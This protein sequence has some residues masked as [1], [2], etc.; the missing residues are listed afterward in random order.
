MPYK[1]KGQCVYKADTGKK[2]GCT[3]GP[4]K[5][6]LAA[7][8]A[9]VPDAKHESTMKTP[10]PS[11]DKVIKRIAKDVTDFQNYV[12]IDAPHDVTA[13]TFYNIVMQDIKD[14]VIKKMWAKMDNRQKRNLYGKVVDYLYEKAKKEDPEYYG[15]DEMYENSNLSEMARNIMQQR[16][17][18]VTPETDADWAALRRYEKG[19]DDG[20]NVAPSM[21]GITFFNV[22]AGKE[23]AARTVGLKQFK[24]G[25]WGHK[26]FSRSQTTGDVQVLKAAE[27]EFGKGRY[28]QPKN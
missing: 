6:Y 5:K 24:S 26:H 1:A 25:K 8:H 17:G 21:V 18:F 7:L 19:D 12:D 28:W 4:V 2:V 27:K 9:N 14:Q 13:D 16:G 3:K 15:D 23:N 22:P 11:L 20:P 10:S